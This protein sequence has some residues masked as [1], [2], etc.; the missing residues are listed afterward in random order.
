MYTG[1]ADTGIFVRKS[2]ELHWFGTPRRYR[3]SF[4]LGIAMV[5]RTVRGVLVEKARNYTGLGALEVSM[6]I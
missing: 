3:C 5:W 2:E 6:F 4:E 1:P